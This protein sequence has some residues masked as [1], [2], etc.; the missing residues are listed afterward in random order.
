[1]AK[2]LPLDA[3]NRLGAFFADILNDGDGQID[4]KERSEPIPA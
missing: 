1:V 3:N 4:I 2:V